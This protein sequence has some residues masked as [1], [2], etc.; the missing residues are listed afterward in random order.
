MIRQNCWSLL[1][2]FELIFFENVYKKRAGK[3]KFERPGG[4]ERV[5][6]KGKKENS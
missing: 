1:R 4:K 5:K 2:N 6:G 3:V